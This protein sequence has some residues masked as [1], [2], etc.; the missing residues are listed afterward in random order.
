MFTRFDGIS[1]D[2]TSLKGVKSN[3]VDYALGAMDILF[4]N[5]DDLVDT[6]DPRNADQGPRI[7]AIKSECLPDFI[8]RFHLFVSRWSPGQVWF[9]R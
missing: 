3:P 1:V 2:M 6:M 5:K 8:N 9:Y 7:Q 4:A